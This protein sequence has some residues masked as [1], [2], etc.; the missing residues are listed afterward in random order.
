MQV[1]QTKKLY[2]CGC[3]YSFLSAQNASDNRQPLELKP[4]IPNQVKRQLIY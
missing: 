2:L 4:P 3:G 1:K